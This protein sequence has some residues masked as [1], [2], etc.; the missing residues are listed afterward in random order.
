[1]ISSIFPSRQRYGVIVGGRHS[2]LRA[3]MDFGSLRYRSRHLA[4]VPCRQVSRFRLAIGC[5]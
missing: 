3:E 4:V 2:T 5:L 1:M